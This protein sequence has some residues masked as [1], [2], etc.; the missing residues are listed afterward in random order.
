[1]AAITQPQLGDVRVVESAALAAVDLPPSSQ[2]YEFH[3]NTATSMVHVSEVQRVA[4]RAACA[5]LDEELLSGSAPNVRERAGFL[6][7]DGMGLGKTRTI[8][9]VPV[10]YTHLT[11]PTN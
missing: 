9:L 11:L 2:A 5:R 1:M 10:S 4:A 7:G 3:P 6:L 8:A